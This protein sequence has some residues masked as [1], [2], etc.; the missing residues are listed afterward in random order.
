[1]KKPHSFLLSSALSVALFA[2]A[3][4]EAQRRQSIADRVA[5]LEQQA[6]APSPTLELLRQIEEMRNEIQGLRAQIEELQHQN[7]ETARSARTQYLDV[8]TRLQRL[9][10]AS[11]PPPVVLDPAGMPDAT[12][13]PPETAGEPAPA[14]PGERAA[15]DA[16]LAAL[17][18]GKYA[19]SARMFADFLDRHPNGPYAPNAV[20]W[21]GESYYVTENYTLALEQFQ[22]LAQRWPN[23]DK[24]PGGM[25]KLGLS[26]L[27]LKQEAEARRTLAAVVKQY[28]GS[29]A[30]RSAEQRLRALGA[31][32]K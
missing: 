6:N 28:P 7:E 2:S 27:G 23:H 21:L 26:Q 10:T 20:Y 25:L 15:Y 13:A 9:E 14:T 29:D 5:A 16:A 8:D 4:A 1:M 12:A 3:P 17:K 31:A 32:K 30:A 18:A 22:S 19:D 24:T 11:A